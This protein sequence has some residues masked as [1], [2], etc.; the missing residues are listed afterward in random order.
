MNHEKDVL[1][2]AQDN[3]FLIFTEKYLGD[4]ECIHVWHDNYGASPDWFVLDFILLK[5][6]A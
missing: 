2:L 5:F 4:I 1:Q 6:E 3:W